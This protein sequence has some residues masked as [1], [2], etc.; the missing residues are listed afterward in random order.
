MTKE[1]LVEY[2]YLA[3][4]SPYG[5]RIESNNPKLVMHR[6]YAVRRELGDPALDE[7]SLVPDRTNLEGALLIVRRSTTIPTQDE[8]DGNEP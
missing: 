3:A 8:T 2:W 4:S 5:V 6:L 7:F 1:E